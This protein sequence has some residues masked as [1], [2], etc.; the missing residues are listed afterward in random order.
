[1]FVLHFIKL[2]LQKFSD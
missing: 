2:V 1:M